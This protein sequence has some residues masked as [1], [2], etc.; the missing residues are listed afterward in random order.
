[1]K[2][3]FFTFL[4]LALVTV[5]CNDRDDDVTMAQIRIKN[6]SAITFDS[7]TVG[8]GENVYLN[9]GPDDYSDY[10]AFEEAFE[11]NFIQIEANGETFVLQPI[12][13]V[14]GTPIPIGFYTYD[15]SIS[16]DGNIVLV[17]VLD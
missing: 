3:N 5:A 14:G 6:S 10:Q 12:D 17:F 4:L 11:F 8:S 1:M 13:F 16:E 9:V 7:V 2:T 15:L